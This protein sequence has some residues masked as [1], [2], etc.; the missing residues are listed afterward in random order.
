MVLKG[1]N[2]NWWQ[3]FLA[4]ALGIA[5]G[6]LSAVY[7]IN[8]AMAAGTVKNGEWQ[9]NENIGSPDASMYLRAAIAVKG[10]MGLRR[11]EVI[12][13]YVERDADGESLT[14]DCDYELVGMPPDARWWSVT[15][16]GEDNF[17]ID[18]DWDLYSVSGESLALKDDG[19]FSI[20]LSADEQTGNWIPTAGNNADAG[21]GFDLTLRLYNPSEDVYRNLATTALPRISRV[22]CTDD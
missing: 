2:I 9:T 15:V 4:A 8:N 12:Y 22:A 10:L 16:Y 3:F 1:I 5:L 14:S 7:A 21:S 11:E 6:V 19:S 13:F 17:L 20:R 18:N